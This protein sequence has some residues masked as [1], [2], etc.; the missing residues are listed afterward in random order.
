MA[1]RI[2]LRASTK[3][4][5][6][7]RAKELLTAKAGDLGLTGITYYIENVSGT[8]LNRP[9]LN[10]LLDESKQG[11]VILVESVDRLSRLSQVDFDT[12]KTK[13]KEKGLKLIVAD[14]PTTYQSN[15]GSIAG[16]VLDCINNMLVDLMATMARLDQEKRIERIKQGQARARELAAAKGQELNK[17]GRPKNI[18]LRD[19]ID[20]YMNRGFKA[21]EIAKQCN[22]G[23]ATVYRIIK[24]IKLSQNL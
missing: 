2:Y 7:E 12:L 11:D 5:D 14:L 15:D 3:E 8:K 24:E 19:K 1:T 18:D 13:L 22:C 16:Q 6:A 21:Q 9:E 10:R 4:Q 23:L 20:G 17:G